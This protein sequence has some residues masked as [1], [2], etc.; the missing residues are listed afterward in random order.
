MAVYSIQSYILITASSSK[1]AVKQKTNLEV[2]KTNL[3]FLNQYH[4]LPV[5]VAYVE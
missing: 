5:T 3:A 4:S 1:N 2:H